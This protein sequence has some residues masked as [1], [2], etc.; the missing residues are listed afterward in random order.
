MA[1]SFR[2][3]FPGSQLAPVA[4]TPVEPTAPAEAAI[5]SQPGAAAATEPTPEYWRGFRAALMLVALIFGGYHVYTHGISLPNIPI[6]VPQ[7][8][9]FGQPGFRVMVIYESQQGM[10]RS[11]NGEIRKYIESKKRP[12]DK[13]P[14]FL[15]VDKD[16]PYEADAEMWKKAASRPRKSEPWI[17]IGSDANGNYEGP[18]PATADELLTLLKKYGGA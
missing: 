4:P 12:D 11:F 14:A 8:N 13:Q 6:I 2:E 17:V 5:P 3:L 15:L 7:S 1:K 18:L 9:V 16:S 10:P